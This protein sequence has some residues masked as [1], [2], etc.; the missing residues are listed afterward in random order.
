MSTRKQIELMHSC[1][2]VKERDYKGMVQ[3][4]QTTKRPMQ[5]S[6]PATSPCSHHRR[7]A[8]AASGWWWRGWCAC[9]RKGRPWASSPSR[10]P[11]SPSSHPTLPCPARGAPP[12]LP[13]PFQVFLFCFHRW[14]GCDTALCEAP[15]EKFLLLCDTSASSSPSKHI[16]LNLSSNSN[17]RF[18]RC[19][20]RNAGVQGTGGC[21]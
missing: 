13:A 9:S 10:P 16:N 18:F 15:V 4:A 7:K 21:G 12:L 2:C 1:Y 11:P 5:T 6:A 19:L 8:R 14:H 17:L 20:E 3:V